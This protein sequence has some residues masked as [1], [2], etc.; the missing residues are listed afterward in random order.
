MCHSTREYLQMKSWKEWRK[1]HPCLNG[2]K[3]LFQREWNNLKAI[4]EQAIDFDEAMD[5]IERTS[6]PG[7]FY[8]G[9]LAWPLKMGFL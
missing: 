6:L 3:K 7:L 4:L 5:E 2:I 1:F 8:D 9:S